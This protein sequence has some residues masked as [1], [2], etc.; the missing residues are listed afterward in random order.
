M[1]F[2]PID[3]SRRF[4]RRIGKDHLEFADFALGALHARDQHDICRRP[5]PLHQTARGLERDIESQCGDATA[6]GL[7]R[8]AI[9]L[10]VSQRLAAANGAVG[11][12]SDGPLGD[13]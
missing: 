7:K 6:V 2:G 11:F 4:H 9:K 10:A 12:D 13:D 3:E 5:S 8:N 1:K